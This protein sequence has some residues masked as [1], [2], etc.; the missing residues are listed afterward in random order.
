MLST[1]NLIERG[2]VFYVRKAVPLALRPIVGKRE[3]IVSLKTSDRATANVRAKVIGLRIDRAL[4][5]AKAKATRMTP[6]AVAKAWKQAVLRED[7]DDRIRRPR[8]D[9][10]LDTESLAFSDMLENTTAEV[11]RRPTPMALARRDA[12]KVM[13]KRTDGTWTPED[14]G[15]EED[16]GP[17]LSEMF[18]RWTDEREPVPKTVAEWTVIRKKFQALALGGVDLPV[19]A[20]TRRQVV[21]FKDALLAQDKAPKT[22]SKALAALSG[23]LT[24]AVANDVLQVNPA[25]GVK[26]TRKVKDHEDN[27]RQT[28][29]DDDARKLLDASAALEGADRWLVWISAY[30]G[31][32]LAET[33]G[34]RG[35]DVRTRDGVLYLAV[36]P[37]AGRP[38]KTKS[39]R[40][41]V[42]VHPALLASGFQEFA[43]RQGDGPLFPEVTADVHGILG[44]AW[45][46]RYGRWARRFVPD[47]RKVFHSWRHTVA[48]KLRAANVPE[49]HRDLIL[50]HSSA[51]RIGR[52]YGD[53]VP[54]RLLLEALAKVTYDARGGQGAAR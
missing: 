20:I 16:A 17:L 47:R 12:V 6:E 52:Q 37:H 11:A 21:A 3:W 44:A 27:K 42:P 41:A 26:V 18:Q 29:T 38:L 19:R 14:D 2:R 39:S 30:S 24:F 23:V 50:G 28:Y 8:S 34:L 10:A 49:E 22:I 25:V 33:A 4:A 48:S 9:D 15:A 32:R 31:L 5:E 35:S 43:R 45:S 36:E 7:L 46:K 53:T 40:R 51:G 13:L 54:L 1:L